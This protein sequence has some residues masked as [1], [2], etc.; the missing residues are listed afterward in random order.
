MWSVAVVSFITMALTL[1]ACLKNGLID[2]NLDNDDG[3]DEESNE[4]A[5]FKFHRYTCTYAGMWCSCYANNR[6]GCSVGCSPNV[7]RILYNQTDCP[8]LDNLILA[9]FQYV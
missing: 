6:G 3:N 8:Q 5:I 7:Y 2:L 9:G 4:L 1:Q